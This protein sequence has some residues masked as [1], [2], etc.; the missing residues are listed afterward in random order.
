MVHSTLVPAF[1]AHMVL[2]H[3]VLEFEP[4]IAVVIACERDV[5]STRKLPIFL[6]TVLVE[7]SHRIKHKRSPLN[8]HLILY[9][10]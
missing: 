2:Q 8:V 9:I 10:K 7:S 5:W 4:Y 3:A 1:T 6:S